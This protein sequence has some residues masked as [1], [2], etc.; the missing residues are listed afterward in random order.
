MPRRV[1]TRKSRAV[2]RNIQ[3]DFLGTRGGILSAAQMMYGGRAGSGRHV[4]C[5]PEEAQYSGRQVGHPVEE[6]QYGRLRDWFNP[7]TYFRRKPNKGYADAQEYREAVLN[8]EIDAPRYEMG[9]GGYDESD[10]FA[11]PVSPKEKIY[12]LFDSVPR[13][14]TAQK[15]KRDI[16]LF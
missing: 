15:K 2:R 7:L 3:R 9:D 10:Y 13:K 12:G 4:G 1:Y 16:V 8:G 6:D 11:V 14:K 5:P